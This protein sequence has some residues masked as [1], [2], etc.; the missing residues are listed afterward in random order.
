MDLEEEEGVMGGF[1]SFPPSVSNFTN[2]LMKC[3]FTGTRSD[4]HVL[5]RDR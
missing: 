4:K 5:C 3:S 2:M 1:F